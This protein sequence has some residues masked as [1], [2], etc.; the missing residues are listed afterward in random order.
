MAEEVKKKDTFDVTMTFRTV[1]AVDTWVLKVGKRYV[2]AVSTGGL[3]LVGDLRMATRFDS[4]NWAAVVGTNVKGSKVVGVR[5]KS[6]SLTG[7]AVTWVRTKD[8]PADTSGE[9]TGPK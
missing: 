1:E 6:P 9:E 3:L 8:V 5:R 2:R 4:V 7:K